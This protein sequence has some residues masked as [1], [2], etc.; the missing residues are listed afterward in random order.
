MKDTSYWPAVPNRKNAAL[1]VVA[2]YLLFWGAW[3]LFAANVL[4]LVVPASSPGLLKGLKEG[5]FICFS[6]V[7]VFALVRGNLSSQRRED[8]RLQEIMRG[9]SAQVGDAFFDQLSLQLSRALNVEY[10]F[11]GQFDDQNGDELKTVAVSVRGKKRANFI[12][13][14]EGSPCGEIRDGHSFCLAEDARRHFP[15]SPLLSERGVESF[16][17]TPLFDSDDNPMGLI[18]VMDGRP[19]TDRYRAESMLRI[20]AARASA[21]LERQRNENAIARL[22]FY[23]SVTGLP[24][25]QLFK[26]RLD[27]A[28]A[29][30]RLKG[31]ELEVLYL[32]FDRFRTIVRTLGHPAEE[33]LLKE[34]SGRL[35]DALEGEEFLA[36]AGSDEFLLM[37]T[38]VESPEKAEGLASRLLEALQAPFSYQGHS[39]HLSASIGLA[40]FPYDGEDTETM[41]RNADAARTRTKQMGGNHYQFYFPDIGNYSLSALI[42]ENRLHQALEKDEF[43]LRYQPQM[44]LRTGLVEGME[45]LV[46][47][48]QPEA[49]PVGPSDFIPLAEETGLIDPIGEWVLREACV[50]NRRWQEAGLPPQRMSVN[51]SARQFFQSSIVELVARILEETGLEGRWLGLEITESV[52]MQDVKQAIDTLHQLKAMGVQVIIDDFGTGYSSLSYLKQFPID[53]LKLYQSFVAGI[54]D[55]TGDKAITAAVIAMAHT[56]NL[57]LVAEGVEKAEQ[58]DFLSEKGCDKIQGFLFSV[59]LKA[60]EVTEL[61][62]G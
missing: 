51:V 41:I 2:G 7:L 36:Q 46:F 10:A 32:D 54:P 33:V 17:G 16:V 5:L 30:A 11:I 42:L 31:Q 22:A 9:V 44:N 45:A 24:K 14:L 52:I 15:H 12:D 29:A 6:A 48:K 37:A 23:D 25:Q 19:I 56:L 38:D 3:S 21:E 47:W 55:D 58:R 40:M 57:E 34:I 18:A 39:L 28:I 35:S 59:P 1:R 61:L 62:S 8:E 4:E 43:A 20:F 50:Q 49:K 26:E 27:E 60:E 13:P 53:T